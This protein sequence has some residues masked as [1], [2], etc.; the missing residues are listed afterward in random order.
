MRDILSHIKQLASKHAEE[1]IA[2]RRH[3]HQFPELSF[4]EINTHL[5]RGCE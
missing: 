1:I 3:I 4:E 5:I 2:I